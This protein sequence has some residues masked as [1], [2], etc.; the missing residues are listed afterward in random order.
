VDLE[1]ELRGE[2]VLDLLNGSFSSPETISAR[3]A[4]LGFDLAEPRYVAVLSLGA[5]NGAD[6]RVDT[7]DQLLSRRRFRD[8]VASRL[9]STSPASMVAVDGDLVVVLAAAAGADGADGAVGLVE[10]VVHHVQAAMPS[11]VISAAIGERCVTTHEYGQS[12][13][14]ARSALDAVFRLGRRGQIVDARSLGVA[15]LIISSGDR[16]TLLDFAHRR[17]GSLLDGGEF[18]RLLL[19]TLRAY[20]DAGFNQRAA[21]RRAFL[22]PNTVAYRLRRVEE[23]LGLSLDDPMLRLEVSLALQIALLAG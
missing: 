12:Y 13:R 9:G 14:L 5:Q 23:R 22:H 1:H 18:E 21:A 20:V 3:V 4:Q 19:A 7:S 11:A 15:R 16:E 2:V 17:L 6:E 10:D 8:L